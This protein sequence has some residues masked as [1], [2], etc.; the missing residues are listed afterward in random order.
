MLKDKFAILKNSRNIGRDFLV[1]VV[2]KEEKEWILE[3]FNHLNPKAVP[4][5][6]ILDK[7]ASNMENAETL[8]GMTDIYNEIYEHNGRFC[9]EINHGDW[10][11]SHKF[12]DV[13]MKTVF[14]VDC[15]LEE[16]TYEDGSDNYSA[17]HYYTLPKESI[18]EKEKTV[19]EKQ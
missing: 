6:E 19:I 1:T 5:T 15:D 11:H 3:E 8:I 4:L 12:A 10:K 14:G 18:F 2:D 9:I 17:I 7:D 16:T 13:L